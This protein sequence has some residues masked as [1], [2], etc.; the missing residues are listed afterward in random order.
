MANQKF[1]ALYRTLEKIDSEDW[2]S[3]LREVMKRLEGMLARK[4]ELELDKDKKLSDELRIEEGV[5]LD[6]TD[7][8]LELGPNLNTDLAD[9]LRLMFTSKEMHRFLSWVCRNVPFTEDKEASRLVTNCI[10][11]RAVSLL[12]TADTG[13]RVMLMPTPGDVGLYTVLTVRAE[14]YNTVRYKAVT[15]IDLNCL[16]SWKTQGVLACALHVV[17]A[18]EVHENPAT[19]RELEVPRAAGEVYSLLV[20][21]GEKIGRGVLTDGHTW[22]FILVRVT[23]DG[24]GAQYNVGTAFVNTQVVRNVGRRLVKNDDAEVVAAVL[25]SWVSGDVIVVKGVV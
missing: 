24:L 6:L 7:K 23:E 9:D 13:R 19:F 21:F 2:E 11:F 8:Q 25:A 4:L 12:E 18:K 20:K 16:S 17:Q 5:H 3:E 22:L 1:K 15:G 10:L 14:K